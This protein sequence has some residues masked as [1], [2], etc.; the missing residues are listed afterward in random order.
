MSKMRIHKSTLF[1]FLILVISGASLAVLAQ[2]HGAANSISVHIF[3]RQKRVP[4]G[5]IIRLEVRV[6][7]DGEAAMLVP[8]TVSIASGSPAY[9]EL[10]LTDGKGRTSPRVN[11]IADYFLLPGQQSDDNAAARI[12]GSWTLLYPHTSLLFEMPIDKGF[13]K[14]MEQPGNYRLS[15]NYASNGISRLH[16]SEKFLTSLPYPSWE[17]K[18]PTNEIFLTVVSVTKK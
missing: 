15:G 5:G 8:N 18:V 11:L 14:F 6:T 17:G 3:A 4:V 12:L 7:N 2:S 16:F 13:F 1:L 9:L 10:E